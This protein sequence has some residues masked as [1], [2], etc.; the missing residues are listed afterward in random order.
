[1][2]WI[3]ISPT[4]GPHVK[5]MKDA[6]MFYTNRVLKEYKGKYIYVESRPDDLFQIQVNTQL[7]MVLILELRTHFVTD[8]F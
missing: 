5:E 6:A 4:P 2:S 7:F 8:L 3:L 1:M